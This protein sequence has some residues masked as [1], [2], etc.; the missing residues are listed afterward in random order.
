[1]SDCVH[2]KVVALRS[3]ETQLPVMWVCDE[4]KMQFFPAIQ[5]AAAANNTNTT[6]S[7]DA[8]TQVQVSP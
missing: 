2:E 5:I 7:T 4:C 6:S 3:A 1:M 8:N